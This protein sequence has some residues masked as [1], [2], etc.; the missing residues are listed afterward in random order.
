MGSGSAGRYTSPSVGFCPQFGYSYGMGTPIG[1]PFKDKMLWLTTRL[2]KTWKSV[3]ESSRQNVCHPTQEGDQRAS[4]CIGTCWK[5]I[6][7]PGFSRVCWTLPAHSARGREFLF[8]YILATG[9]CWPIKQSFRQNDKMEGSGVGRGSRGGEQRNRKEPRSTN[10]A[11]GDR[12]RGNDTS[13]EQTT[14][15]R[16]LA[17]LHIQPTPRGA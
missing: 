3:V 17:S 8:Y 7:P 14:Q 6:Q 9:H 15:G 4:A 16:T 11:Q 12:H 5:R 2:L 10:P 1:D 13:G